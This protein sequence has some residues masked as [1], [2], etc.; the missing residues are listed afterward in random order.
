MYIA[1]VEKLVNSV[2]LKS[3]ALNMLTGSSPVTGT[4]LYLTV[5]Q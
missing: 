3:T 2:D 1:S 5:A 4:K